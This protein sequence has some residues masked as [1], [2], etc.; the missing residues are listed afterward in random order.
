MK[1]LVDGMEE[2]DLFDFNG[3]DYFDSIIDFFSLDETAPYLDTFGARVFDWAKINVPEINVISIFSGAG[4]LDIG[5]R[6]AGFK[7]V[8]HLE[9][10]EDF[11][12]TLNMNSDYFNNAEIINIDIR[13]YKPTKKQCHFIIG[14]PPCQTFSAAGRRAAG[15]QGIDD[16]KGT[17]FEEYIRLLK[18]YKPQGFLFENVYGITGA[19]AGKAWELIKT[20]FT[21][22]GYTI[23]FRI[24]NTA[25]Y[26]V[27][28]FRERMIIVGTKQGNYRF[29]RPTHGPDSFAK[30]PYYSARHA[31]LN[32]PVNEDISKLKVNGRHGYLLNDI[33]PGLNYSFYTEKMGHPN[34]IF[35]WRSKFSDY[36]YKA[37]PDKPVRTIKA[38]AGQYTGPLHWENRYLTLNEF[39]R[40]QSFPDTYQLFGNRQRA[41][42]QIGN[43]VPPQFARMLALSIMNQVFNVSLPFNMDYLNDS[44]VL[45]FRKR[46]A[47][48]TEEYTGKA[49]KA[50]PADSKKD[51]FSLER[52]HEFYIFV[53]PE[54]KTIVNQHEG[55]KIQVAAEGTSLVFSLRNEADRKIYYEIIITPMPS[56]NWNMI[57]DKVVLRSYSSNVWSYTVC[58]KAFEYFLKT[59][60][61]KDDIVQ[62]N[63][64]YQYK[65]A[66]DFSLHIFEQNILNNEEWLFIFKIVK[67]K[68]IRKILSYND[69]SFLLNMEKDKIELVA[70]NLK[71]L[72]YEI[73]NHNTNPQIKKGHILLPYLFPTLS[74]LSVQLRKQL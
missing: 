33:P 63:G 35:A 5:F 23:N 39:K 9:L 15:V 59:N 34:P 45:T 60:K 43:S 50:F 73:R 44:E 11:C 25:D 19:Q 42:Q 74:N 68:P 27:P 57:Y 64:Y 70:M 58:W 55:Q 2:L 71:S 10:E 47:L 28:Q 32:V 53:T 48:L 1:A 8:S 56:S 51:L 49:K 36:L 67:A 62:L 69:F 41:L 29:P 6:D 3:K 65:P 20:E 61:I 24:L 54:F 14:G 30:R 13:D 72:G 18:F 46:K 21:N 37:D 4:G 12:R 38:Q 22:A 31:L 7:V 17:L 52:N 66:I 26:G 16:H 40:L